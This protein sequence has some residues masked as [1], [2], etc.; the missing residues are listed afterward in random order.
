MDLEFFFCI[1]TFIKILLFK[2]DDSG[3]QNW[4]RLLRLQLWTVNYGYQCYPKR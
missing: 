3:V 4:R 1:F 2:P